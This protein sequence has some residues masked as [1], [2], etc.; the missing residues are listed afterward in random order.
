MSDGALA[1]DKGVQRVG[2]EC[3]TVLKGWAAGSPLPT[4]GKGPR[5]ERGS[6]GSWGF[7]AAQCEHRGLWRM[8]G[9]QGGPKEGGREF[10]DEVEH[11][12]CFSLERSLVQKKDGRLGEREGGASLTKDGVYLPE[13]LPTQT[14]GTSVSTRMAQMSQVQ[15]LFH[16]AAQQVGLGGVGGAC[17]GTPEACEQRVT[18]QEA[19]WKHSSALF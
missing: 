3:E 16:E 13:G 14:T 19:E 1:L 18:R 11:G 7:S 8:S 15:E 6:W 17:Q 5:E 2:E 4:P 9:I 10:L 12:C